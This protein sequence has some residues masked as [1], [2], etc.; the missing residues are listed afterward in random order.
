MYWFMKGWEEGEM[1]ALEEGSIVG[2]VLSDGSINGFVERLKR[3]L[4]GPSA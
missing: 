4:V 1:L 3:V 2:I